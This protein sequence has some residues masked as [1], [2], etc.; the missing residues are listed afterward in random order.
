MNF[1]QILTALNKNGYP[2]VAVCLERKA[3]LESMGSKSV[4][5][6][7]ADVINEFMRNPGKI[8]PEDIVIRPEF[9]TLQAVAQIL[10]RIRVTEF[11]R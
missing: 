3:V 11:G 4:F 1:I 10:R 7:Y 8:C 9:T 2:E 6:M 5:D